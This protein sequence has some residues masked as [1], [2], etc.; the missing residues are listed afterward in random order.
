MTKPEESKPIFSG[1]ESEDFW[2]EVRSIDNN[3]VGDDYYNILYTLGCMCQ[4][5]ELRVREL[6]LKLRSE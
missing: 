6:E 3:T 5:L 2:M 1:E 4:K